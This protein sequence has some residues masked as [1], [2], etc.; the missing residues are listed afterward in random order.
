[1][2]AQPPP[3]K[4][5]V[6]GQVTDA[7]T[8]NPIEGATVTFLVPPRTPTLRGAETD[9]EGRF[10]LPNVPTG[11]YVLLAGARGYLD[12]RR[13]L[14]LGDQKEV[15]VDVALVKAP[16]L[17][18]RVL[19][20]DG[21]PAAQTEVTLV[22]TVQVVGT[23]RGIRETVTTDGEGLFRLPLPPGR[24]RGFL[25]APGSGWAELRLEVRPQQDPEELALTLRPLGR[26]SGRVQDEATGAVVAEVEVSCW[27]RGEGSGPLH[28]YPS[29]KTDAQGRF[30]LS[31]LPPGQFLLTVVVPTYLRASEQVA[32]RQGE[33]SKVVLALERGAT[34]RGVVL[35][36]D[37]KTPLAGAKV[38]WGYRH[39]ARTDE[40]G[41]FVLER[42]GP[43]EAGVSNF[44]TTGP[45]GQVVRGVKFDVAVS[46]EGLAPHA[47]TVSLNE[48]AEP[49]EIRFVMRDRGGTISGTAADLDQH[50]PLAGETVVAVPD[51]GHGTY[52]SW[53]SPVLKG[54]GM[55][56]IEML[57]GYCT[58]HNRAVVTAET[59]DQGR[60]TLGNVPEGR[61]TLCLLR[62][63]RSLALRENVEI[64]EGETAEGLDLEVRRRPGDLLTGRVL[65]AAGQPLA[66][67]SMRVT[68]GHSGPGGSCG[69]SSTDIRTDDTGRYEL[70]LRGAGRYDL[71]LLLEGYL[72]LTRELEISADKQPGDVDLTLQPE[73]PGGVPT[74][75]LS[76]RVFLPDG[77]TPAV[78][79]KVTPF[80]KDAPFPEADSTFNARGSAYRSCAAL[81]AETEAQGSFVI[82]GLRPAR[83]GVFATPF[84]TY[85][86]LEPRKPVKSDYANLLP[87]VSD[88]AEVTANQ[89]TKDVRVMLRQGG[90]LLVRV[91]D[92]DTGKPVA[93][94]QLRLS[95]EL[96]EDLPLGNPP[97]S[98]FAPEAT[99]ERGA[100]RAQGLASGL[101]R[102]TVSAPGYQTQQAK[103]V[104]VSGQEQT[105]EV[106]LKPA[107]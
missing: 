21:Q 77:K 106:R 31:D 43:G 47:Q 26:V 36:P 6:R 59:D 79:V 35:G 39:E 8:G 104:V 45:D 10:S 29:T 100:H 94:A 18:G 69:S 3:P 99:D 78:G 12:G 56:S 17:R 91:L 30:L 38:V 57:R 50:Q 54:A 24:H 73:P 58:Q 86:P 52:Q 44:G 4:F 16:V 83:W 2:E 66:N 82:Q 48:G 65:Q 28:T 25:I 49:P 103:S 42:I 9:R 13:S 22:S 97:Y 27:L 34:V 107:R 11:T 51:I 1:V 5:T 74:G 90:S 14:T 88:L 95:G 64:G 76:G 33:E 55:V 80:T 40:Q 32:V 62:R 96:A 7:A 46:A 81:G 60:F 15:T 53:L 23:S 101:Y 89:E 37:E 92:A 41:R 93:Q 68:Y 19:K 87:A 75:S 63:G 72:P 102:V 98:P 70:P 61:Y 67:T 105:L 20:P 71:T 85:R 84:E